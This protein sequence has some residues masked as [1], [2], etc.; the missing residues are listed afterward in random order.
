MAQVSRW[1]TRPGFPRK[2]PPLPWMHG[3]ISSPNLNPARAVPALASG[4]WQGLP[5]LSI[6]LMIP[7]ALPRGRSTGPPPRVPPPNLRVPVWGVPS[8]GRASP[9]PPGPGGLPG[10][11]AAPGP[12]RTRPGILRKGPLLPWMHGAISS[13]NDVPMPSARR[14]R[15]AGGSL[16]VIVRTVS[17]VRGRFAWPLRCFVVHDSH[18]FSMI[19]SGFA[20]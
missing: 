2:G 20:L 15:P 9:P 8:P 14:T 16:C 5:C 12:G 1:E 10:P 7:R 3:A 13:P 19:F 6:S 4:S 11:A 18:I 17:C